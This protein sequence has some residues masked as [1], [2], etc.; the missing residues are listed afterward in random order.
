MNDTPVTTATPSSN[1]TP[2][3]RNHHPVGDII[4]PVYRD[5]VQLYL[6]TLKDK[7]EVSNSYQY[8]EQIFDRVKSGD[9]I[10]ATEASNALRAAITQHLHT[11]SESYLIY[12]AYKLYSNV[13]CGEVSK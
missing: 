7:P 3:S 1:T 12:V 2:T 8:F 4:S 6:A 10:T 13:G 11:Q 5:F 9:S